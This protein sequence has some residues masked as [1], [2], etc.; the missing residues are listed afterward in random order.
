MFGKLHR[1]Q[2]QPEGAEAMMRSIPSIL[3]GEFFV[4]DSTGPGYVSRTL[5]EYSA[6]RDQVKV[7]F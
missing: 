5:A 2:R 3:R 6:A 7:R 4:F 1:A